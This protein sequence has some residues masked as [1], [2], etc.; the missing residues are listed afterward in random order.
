MT[1][2]IPEIPVG[3]EP[4]VNDPRHIEKTRQEIAEAVGVKVADVTPQEE[5]AE[6][7]VQDGVNRFLEDVAH[8]PNDQL[9]PATDEK[10]T[11]FENLGEEAAA[12]NP[13]ETDGKER[14]TENTNVINLEAERQRRMEDQKKA[15]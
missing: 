4:G 11:F 7:V 15:A 10:Q 5:V 6:N 8:A 12:L 9:N 3:A 13:F 2:N 1:N 14:V